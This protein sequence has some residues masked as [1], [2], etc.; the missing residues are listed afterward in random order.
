M[1]GLQE[2]SGGGGGGEIHVDEVERP[3]F[4][5]AEPQRK[6]GKLGDG[7]DSWDDGDPSRCPDSSFF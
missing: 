3:G 5:A 7:V 1:G 6:M 2:T 4:D